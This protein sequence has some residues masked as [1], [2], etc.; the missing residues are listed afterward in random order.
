[1]IHRL[2]EVLA[3]DDYEEQLL[4]L[5]PEIDRINAFPV[6]EKIQ[7]ELPVGLIKFKVFNWLLWRLT[8]R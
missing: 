7:L 2:D 5:K 1:M 8:G 4:R 3:E 6:S